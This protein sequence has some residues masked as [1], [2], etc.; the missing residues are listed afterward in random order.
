[1]LKEKVFLVY[2]KKLTVCFD[3]VPKSFYLFINDSTVE[4]HSTDNST[5]EG[6]LNLFLKIRSLALNFAFLSF[7]DRL[8]IF[9]FLY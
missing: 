5:R 3:L 1:M 8:G 7:V 6:K 4:L 2:L 9:I